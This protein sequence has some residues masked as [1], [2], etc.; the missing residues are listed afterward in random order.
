MARRT[1]V[2]QVSSIAELTYLPASH[3]V[4]IASQGLQKHSSAEP[5]RPHAPVNAPFS[6]SAAHKQS[7]LQPTAGKTMT[8]II[9][10]LRTVK[11]AAC[12]A[13]GAYEHQSLGDGVPLCPGLKL[14]MPLPLR[15]GRDL[16]RSSRCAA[17]HP[18]RSPPCKSLMIAL[19][20]ANS[21]KNITVPT[22]H[23]SC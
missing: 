11:H 22:H 12:N 9:T 5:Q 20:S 18:S 13:S 14:V 15:L 8:Y 10:M 16:H 4:I 1:R 7:L 2:Q 21:C 23:T 19:S 6:Q 3:A 17:H